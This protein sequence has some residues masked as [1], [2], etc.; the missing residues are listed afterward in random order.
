MSWAEIRRLAREGVLFGSHGHAHR[1]LHTLDPLDR[2]AELTTS[3]RRLEDALGQEVP[4]IAYP[5][6]GCSRPVRKAAERAGYR[7]GLTV[8]PG[9]CCRSTARLQLPRLEVN[10][11][12]PFSDFKDRVDRFLAP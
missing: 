5:Y 8:E 2:A 11:T 4:S 9:V 6:G 10:G 12:L 7:F 1:A 3:K